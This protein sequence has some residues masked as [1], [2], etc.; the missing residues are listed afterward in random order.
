MFENL[1]SNYGTILGG[2]GDK[3]K[4]VYRGPQFTFPPFYR[5]GLIGVWYYD[6]RNPV[7]AASLGHP[8]DT[9]ARPQY[10]ERRG[11]F[12]LRLIGSRSFQH[13][14]RQASRDHLGTEA[15]RLEGQA[16]SRTTTTTTKMGQLPS[17]QHPN[18]GLT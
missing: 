15:G 1:D 3:R 9:A 16:P 4:A 2:L 5:K 11:F 8:R 7:K 13:F 14:S 12:F 10:K 17:C 6:L 18:W